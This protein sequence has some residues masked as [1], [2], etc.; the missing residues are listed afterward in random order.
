MLANIFIEKS[1]LGTKRIYDYNPNYTLN[2]F[3]LYL[4]QGL[5]K[6][7]I[8]VEPIT[9]DLIGDSYDILDITNNIYLKFKAFSEDYNENDNLNLASSSDKF[10]ELVITYNKNLSILNVFCNESLENLSASSIEFISKI[11]DNLKVI[12]KTP[13]YSGD[14][15]NELD[16]IEYE[17]IKESSEN[18]ESGSTPELIKE[19]V[20]YDNTTEKAEEEEV[21]VVESAKPIDERKAWVMEELRLKQQ[22]QSE[23]LEQPEQE[24]QVEQEEQPEQEEQV[25]QVE[26]EEQPEIIPE[27]IPAEPEI[28]PGYHVE[29]DELVVDNVDVFNNLEPEPESE[30]TVEEATVVEEEKPVEENAGFQEGVAEGE[31]EAKEGEY[32]NNF[33]ADMVDDVEGFGSK[34][35]KIW[36]NGKDDVLNNNLYFTPIIENNQQAFLVEDIDN[37]EFTKISLNDDNSLELSM[38]TKDEFAK[39]YQLRKDQ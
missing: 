1:F 13:E 5:L 10:V 9:L 32:V 24:E 22:K 28:D 6:N 21:E 20:I 14:E 2:R 15:K 19:E 31:V 33:I 12:V 29:E 35:I 23:Q 18:D 27:E 36:E 37:N 17:G 39:L 25:E 38:I 7:I 30:S 4:N 11:I 16:K 34:V 26:Q 8:Y 3:T